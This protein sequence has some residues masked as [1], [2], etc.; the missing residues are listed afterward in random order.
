MYYYRRKLALLGGSTGKKFLFYDSPISITS[1]DSQRL[2][3][4][5]SLSGWHQRG[6]THDIVCFGFGYKVLDKTGLRT[7]PS[8]DRK[9]QNY[10]IYFFFLNSR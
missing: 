5:F 9:V 10:T 1:S 3:F 8:C 2:Y 6:C 4:F 7:E